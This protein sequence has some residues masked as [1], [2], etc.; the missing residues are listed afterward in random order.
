MLS[1]W[2]LRISLLVV[3]V[4]TTSSGPKLPI[5]C[6]LPLCKNYLVWGNGAVVSIVTILAPLRPYSFTFPASKTYLGRLHLL[7][8]N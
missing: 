3:L 8:W 2:L 5:T 1:R 4:G 6:R 7:H